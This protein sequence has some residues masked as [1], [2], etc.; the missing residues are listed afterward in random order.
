MVFRNGGIVKQTEKWL[1]Q[2]TE[3]EIV[4]IIKYLG[5]YFTTKLIWS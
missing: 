2:G 4:S 1:Y 3:I 5:L